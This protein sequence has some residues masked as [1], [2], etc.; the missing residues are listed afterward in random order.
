MA[1]AQV[2]VSLKGIK[3]LR[4]CL[5]NRD[6]Y[7]NLRIRFVHEILRKRGEIKRELGRRTPAQT[8]ELRG[9]IR[10]RGEKS[11][12]KIGY[13]APYAP[14]VR[15]RRK[16][17]GAASTWETLEKYRRSRQLRQIMY[18]ARDEAFRKLKRDLRK[19]GCPVD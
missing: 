4:T 16:R 6:V 13:A 18:A 3:E 11:Q 2:K 19:L 17:F 12:A 5:S 10:V 9:S 15:Y 7:R 14:Y 1:R 8:G